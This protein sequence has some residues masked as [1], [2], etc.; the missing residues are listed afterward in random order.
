MADFQG[1]IW[2]PWRMQYIEGIEESKRVEGCFLCRYFATPEED[3]GNFVLWR[4]EKTLVL[5]NRYPYA[6]GH[7]LI[8]PADH[9][10]QPEDLDEATLVEL[11]LRA[12]DAKCV[13]AAALEAQGFNIGLNLGHC[14][15]AGLPEHLHW[16]IVP[17]WN[18]DTNFMPVFGDVKVIPESLEQVYGKFWAA[19]AKLGLGPA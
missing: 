8:A 5:L 15:G 1:S 16:H 13:L 7:V 17:R 9:R 6:N 2:A 11:T 10:A 14:A 18:G 4:S 3:E 19:S 12:R